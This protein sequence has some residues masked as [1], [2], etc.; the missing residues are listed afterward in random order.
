MRFKKLIAAVLF[1]TVTL[2]VGTI[3]P[4]TVSAASSKPIIVGSKSVPESKTVSEIYAIA[5]EHAGYK[6]TR[7]QNI[8]NSVVYKAVKT[9]QVDVYPEYT[10][11][12]VTAYLKKNGQGKSAAQMASIA[13][14]GVAKDGLTTFKYA[15]D[16]NRQGVGIRTSVA[17][18][19]NIKN[20]SD[21]QKKADK[22][23]FASQGEFEKRP[24]ALPLMDK[25]YGKFRFKSIKDYDANLLYKI[26]EQGKADAAPVSTTDGQLATSKFQL[27]KDNKNIWPPYNLVPLANKQA[28][29]RYPKM[30]K[31]L[32]KV[33][34][35]LTTKA[36][37]QLNKQV[38][39]DGQNYRTVAQN[40]YNKNMK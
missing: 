3:V 9:G 34:A 18:K 6:V 28:V 17:K 7:K 33:D 26:M 20:L 31:T 35:K 14:R 21:L 36:V 11:T 10:G 8:S 16:D 24:D 15:P 29:K 22:I 25:A 40:W 39:V 2:L 13:Q 37:T 5:L 38:G 12:I 19:Y 27:V 1:A 32:N 23:R 30:E 4:A